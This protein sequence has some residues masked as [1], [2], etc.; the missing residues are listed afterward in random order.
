MR[1]SRVIFDISWKTEI[2]EGWWLWLHRRSFASQKVEMDI[3]YTSFI[4]VVGYGVII[5]WGYIHKED[6]KFD[7]SCVVDLFICNKDIG[8][9]EIVVK[10]ECYICYLVAYGFLP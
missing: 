10:N 6:S 5:E 8:F 3:A 1:R 9:V 2:P 7:R 4:L